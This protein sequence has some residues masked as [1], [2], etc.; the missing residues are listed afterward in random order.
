MKGGEVRL[1]AGEIKVMKKS[2]KRDED[3]EKK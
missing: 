1:M 3:C 2:E